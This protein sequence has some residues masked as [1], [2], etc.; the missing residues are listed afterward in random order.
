MM[1]DAV[2]AALEEI[3]RL[4]NVPADSIGLSLSCEFLARAAIEKPKLVRTLGLISPTG[5]EGKARDDEGGTRG[6]KWLHRTLNFPLWSGGLFRLLTT[7]VVIRKFLLKT[8]G[9]KNI[10]EPLLEYDC[11]TTHQPG[12]EHA[13]YYFVSGFLFSRDILNIYRALEHPVWMVHGTRGDF[14]DYHHA[15]RVKGR[16]NWR[17]IYLTQENF[18]TSRPLLRWR[19]PAKAFSAN[20][21]LSRPNS[22]TYRNGDRDAGVKK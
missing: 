22:S 20:Q 7:K 5:F 12:A 10:D 13:P 9:S 2:L 1:T 14:V 4:H 6:R 3:R 17:S 21:F 15:S 8:W 16:T 11:Q 19:P 18:R